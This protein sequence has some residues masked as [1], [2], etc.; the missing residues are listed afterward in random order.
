M[1]IWP[2][3]G[4]GGRPAARGAELARALPIFITGVPAGT[5]RAVP[6]AECVDEALELVGE[7]NLAIDGL[8]EVRR[9]LRGASGDAELATSESCD[10]TSASMPVIASRIAS[11]W[12]MAA[13]AMA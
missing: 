5:A 13:A 11:S 8:R 4:E 12:T 6:R 7:T 9:C 10:R 3:A 2:G 1:R